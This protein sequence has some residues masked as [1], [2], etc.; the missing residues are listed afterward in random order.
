MSRPD[1][2]SAEWI[3]QAIQRIWPHVARAMDTK[4]QAMIRHRFGEW[5]MVQIRSAHAGNLCP[6]I[7]GICTYKMTSE[8]VVVDVG[9]RFVS[10]E[11]FSIGIVLFGIPLEI[12]HISFDGL[13]RIELVGLGGELPC[14]DV[15][16][17]ALIAL[18]KIDV[19]AYVAGVN[20]CALPLVDWAWRHIVSNILRQSFLWPKHVVVALRGDADS[21][22]DDNGGDATN[23]SKEYCD[24]LSL[25]VDV[26][27]GI[28]IE[29][30]SDTMTAAGS[31]FVCTLRI[32]GMEHRT[33]PSSSSSMRGRVCEEAYWN[34]SFN[35]R[36][37]G[38][39]RRSRQQRD[40][41]RARSSRLLLISIFDS[42][43]LRTKGP[44]AVPVGIAK[45]AI[46]TL[47]LNR[48]T[49]TR[50]P[51]VFVGEGESSKNDD[52]A[53]P[54]SAGHVVL[55]LRVG[56]IK[57]RETP[58]GGGDMANNDNEIHSSKNENETASIASSSPLSR[59]SGVHRVTVIVHRCANLVRSKG[60]SYVAIRLRDDATTTQK[61]STQV[62]VTSSPVWE[63]RIVF[64]VR[65]NGAH[66][67]WTSACGDAVTCLCVEVKGHNALMPDEFLGQTQIS[68]YE[69][70]ALGR[71]VYKLSGTDSGSVELTVFCESVGS[72]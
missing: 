68:I 60:G 26:I 33:Q 51:L 50:V 11:R 72:A 14:V 29:S 15:A 31:F 13:V 9:V 20:I 27:A 8:C 28:G 16:N 12:S 38:A 45:V 69:Q 48:T 55:R 71:R 59:A 44:A 6:T 62:R 19:G 57:C 30:K 58:D 34:E 36:V 37:N 56:K 43:A 1:V 18:P 49:S 46:S 25:T 53:A 4:I 47:P 3:N 64:V 17:V 40:S 54:V 21:A 22:A 41:N 24:A 7:D 65:T 39:H 63:E 35:F 5:R 67:A 70:K 61:T 42:S 2:E 32:A 52:K 66:R 10:D 23:A